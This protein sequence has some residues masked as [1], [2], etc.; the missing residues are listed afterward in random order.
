[1]SAHD[2]TIQVVQRHTYMYFDPAL[3]SGFP[4]GTAVVELAISVDG[5]A[6][7]CMVSAEGQ[8]VELEEWFLDEGD[9][10]AEIFAMYHA[11]ALEIINKL[12]YPLRTTDGGLTTESRGEYDI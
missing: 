2:L 3:E 10:I 5:P 1:M 6:I 8:I 12:C 4:I 9:S 11:D 7:R